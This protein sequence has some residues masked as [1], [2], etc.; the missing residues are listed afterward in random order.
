[1]VAPVLHCLQGAFPAV[2]DALSWQELKLA[3]EAGF[4]QLLKMQEAAA[5]AA[6]GQQANPGWRRPGMTR[7][8][9]GGGSTAEAWVGPAQGTCRHRTS[10]QAIFGD[11]A[12][13]GALFTLQMCG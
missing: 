9:G 13:P 11:L 1:M 5:A 6:A 10:C 7:A 3:A 4:E 2:D 8:T 12:A